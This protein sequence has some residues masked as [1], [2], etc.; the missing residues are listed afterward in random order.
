MSRTQ[1]LHGRKPRPAMDMSRIL[2]AFAIMLFMLLVSMALIWKDD[3]ARLEDMGRSVAVDGERVLV[4]PLEKGMARTPVHVGGGTGAGSRTLSVTL[5]D[6]R[7]S[8]ARRFRL[9]SRPYEADATIA[10]DFAT[11]RVLRLAGNL[12]CVTGAVRWTNYEIAVDTSAPAVKAAP[13]LSRTP[14]GIPSRLDEARTT[15]LC[16]LPA[17]PDLAS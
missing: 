16:E 13:P 11:Y 10:R 14:E 12:D 3:A 6:E 7:M 2:V 8:G 1:Q 15:I 5:L 9:S 17:G 4:I